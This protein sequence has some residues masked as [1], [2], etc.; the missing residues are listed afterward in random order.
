M[1]ILEQN[2]AEAGSLQSFDVGQ[3][4]VVI[5][6]YSNGRSRQIGQLALA[7]FANPEG[8]ERV[9]GAWR[10]TPNSGLAQVG[11]AGDGGRGLMSVGTVEMSSVDLAE[12][13]AR[14]IVAQRGFQGNARVV[15]TADEVLQE[16]VNLRR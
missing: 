8:L 15:T 10:A 7:S 5:G 3:D 2:G 14:L 13:F 1:T 12:E 6:S 11:E 9:A 16:V 4:G